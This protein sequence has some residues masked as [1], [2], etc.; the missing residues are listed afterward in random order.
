[1]ITTYFVLQNPRNSQICA[2]HRRGDRGADGQ[3][4]LVGKK[5]TNRK[6]DVNQEKQYVCIYIYMDVE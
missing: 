4:D 5:S 6:R 2:R 1:L 3:D